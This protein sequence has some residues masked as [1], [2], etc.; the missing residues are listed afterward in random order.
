MICILIF[1]M[2]RLIK[3]R[4]KIIRVFLKKKIIIDLLDFYRNEIVLVLKLFF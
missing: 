3:F 1:W 4:Y 2:L